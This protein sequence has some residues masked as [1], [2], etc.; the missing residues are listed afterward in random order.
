MASGLAALGR[1][2]GQADGQRWGAIGPRSLTAEAIATTPRLA[3]V[4]RVASGSL[5]WSFW[6]RCGAALS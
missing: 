2:R 5:P 3:H 1:G 6:E 4:R